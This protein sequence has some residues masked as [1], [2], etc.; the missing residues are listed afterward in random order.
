MQTKKSLVNYN[1]YEIEI[2]C[3]T[4]A[5]TTSSCRLGPVLCIVW[6][7]SQV[8]VVGDLGANMSRAVETRGTAVQI[9]ENI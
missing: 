7:P 5:Q 4:W 2:K 3:F 9:N 8:A 6:A 1:S